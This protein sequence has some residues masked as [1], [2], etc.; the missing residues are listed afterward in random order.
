[1]AT[2]IVFSVR[3]EGVDGE[4]GADR[5]DLEVNEVFVI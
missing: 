1:M 2:A 4:D 5:E 3:A